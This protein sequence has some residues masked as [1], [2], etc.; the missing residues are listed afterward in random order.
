MGG[1][2]LV[3]NSAEQFD[4]YLRSDIRKWA[5]AVK[6]RRDRR[7]TPLRQEAKELFR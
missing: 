5:K 2:T 6:D 1:E 7:L 4:L 3:G